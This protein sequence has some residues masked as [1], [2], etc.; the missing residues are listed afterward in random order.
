MLIVFNK[1]DFLTPILPVKNNLKG[2]M[3]IYSFNFVPTPI[4][5]KTE[6]IILGCCVFKDKIKLFNSS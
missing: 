2:S 6:L 5:I 3:E 1:C 4:G